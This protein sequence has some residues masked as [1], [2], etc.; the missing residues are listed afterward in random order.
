MTGEVLISL[1]PISQTLLTSNFTKACLFSPKQPE[2]SVTKDEVQ[3]QTNV[4]FGPNF[5]CVALE[6]LR[7]FGEGTKLN[8]L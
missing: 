2:V 7:T 4:G 3:V 8:I 5:V 6:H 1:V